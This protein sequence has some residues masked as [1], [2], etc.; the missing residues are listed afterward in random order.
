MRLRIVGLLWW[1]T[2]AAASATAVVYEGAILTPVVIPGFSPGGLMLGEA[3]LRQDG[4]SFEFSVWVQQMHLVPPPEPRQFEFVGSGGSLLATGTFVGEFTISGCDV[5]PQNPFPPDSTGEVQFIGGEDFLS[6][7]CPALATYY[8][9]DGRFESAE[10]ID[11]MRLD[12]H[13]VARF[14]RTM[15]VP[16]PTASLLALIAAAFLR[17]RRR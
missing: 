7:T 10:P 3:F 14:E 11:Q 5:S 16:E 12:P 4:T 13:S 6:I 8:R 17:G 2:A 15:P 1:A 9:F